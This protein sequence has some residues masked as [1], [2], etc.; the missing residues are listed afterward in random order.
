MV[1]ADDEGLALATWGG[2]EICEEA[3]ARAPLAA[4][5]AAGDARRMRFGGLELFLCAVG[6]EPPARGRS[7]ERSACGVERILGKWIAA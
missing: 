3:A 6:G 1:L 2:R 4:P 5:R 7:L